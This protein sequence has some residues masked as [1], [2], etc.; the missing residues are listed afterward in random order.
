[1]VFCPIVTS[2][3]KFPSVR[4]LAFFGVPDLVIPRKG[5]QRHRIGA[6]TP[7]PMGAV[8]DKTCSVRSYENKVFVEYREHRPTA[9]LRAIGR[10]GSMHVLCHEHGASFDRNSRLTKKWFGTS[11]S[12]TYTHSGRT[13]WA[14][15]VQSLALISRR[16]EIVFHALSG[17]AFPE[18]WIF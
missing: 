3:S 10:S 1:M 7:T 16:L 5:A 17:S 2:H 4:Q 15:G 18:D 9:S 6:T 11:L 12:I 14:S 13:D 8:S